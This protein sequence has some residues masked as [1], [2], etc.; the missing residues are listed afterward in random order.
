MVKAECPAAEVNLFSPKL[1]RPYA[2]CSAWRLAAI[3]RIEQMRPVVVV[4]SSSSAYVA[5]GTGTGG[6][7]ASPPAWERGLRSTLASLDTAGIPVVVIRD[8]PRLD[9]DAPVCLSRAAASPARHERCTFEKDAVTNPEATRAES[10]AARGLAHVVLVDFGD[11][12]CAAS[13][14]RVQ[15]DDTVLFFDSNH[16]TAGYSVSFA[17]ALGDVIDQLL[18]AAQGTTPHAAGRGAP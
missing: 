12:I 5:Q 17:K 1:N 9:F 8:T 15:R 7:S 11:A 14:C 10:A 16:L 18:R 13:P 6:S 3:Q 4:I 2:E